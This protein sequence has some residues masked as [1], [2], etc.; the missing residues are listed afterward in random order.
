MVQPKEKRVKFQMPPSAALTVSE[1]LPKS[2][3]RS[4]WNISVE[5]GQTTPKREKKNPIFSLN[6]AE[7]E[8]C[9]WHLDFPTGA[10]NLCLMVRAL[11]PGLVPT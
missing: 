2:D 6:A 7:N 9:F 4:K 5:N 11:P 3:V 10:L 1:A 8:F